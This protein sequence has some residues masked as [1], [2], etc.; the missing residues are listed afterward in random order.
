[1]IGWKR[2]NQPKPWPKKTVTR[3]EPL[4]RRNP[5]RESEPHRAR[6]PHKKS[7]PLPKRNPQ[8]MSEP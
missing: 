8:D 1:M 4:S 6:N 2:M 3:S 7:E 5:K